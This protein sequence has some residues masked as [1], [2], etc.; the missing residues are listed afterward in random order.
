MNQARRFAR[1]W[2]YRKRGY[3][4]LEA[5]KNPARIAQSAAALK[6][7]SEDAIDSFFGDLY[8][9]LQSIYA[10]VD[11]QIEMPDGVTPEEAVYQQ[12]IYLGMDEETVSTYAD[13]LTDPDVVDLL[14]EDITGTSA[15]EVDA[16]TVADAA[17]V[18]LESIP[19]IRNGALIEAVSGVHVHWDDVLGQY[20]TRWGAQPDLERD[21]H[22]RIEIF[23]YEPNSLVDLK[24]QLIR[25][26]VCQARDCY[27]GMGIS[28]PESFQ[29][30]GHGR[31]DASTWYAH[32]D[33]YDEY[34]DPDAEISTWY[35]E[36]TPED[37][38]E[39]EASTPAFTSVLEE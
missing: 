39:H 14:K 22:A 19:N 35:E 6:P 9:H 10:D 32:Y 5:T 34:F 25:N 2:V 23:A 15:D 30:L 3:D 8:K 18:D 38:Y 37:A 24:T 12:D 20:H 13:V 33:F 29:I 28:P 36:Q 21:P 4:T 16:E 11:S 27:L 1:Y 17:G 7:L 26:L 31:H